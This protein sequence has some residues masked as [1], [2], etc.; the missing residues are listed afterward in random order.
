[1]SETSRAQGYQGLLGPLY[2]PNLVA[3]MA[4]AVGIVIGS[5]GPWAHLFAI[6]KGGT[7]GDGLITLVLGLLATLALF[8]VLNLG[9]LGTGSGWIVWLSGI[10]A[11]M[12]LVCACVAIVDMI[13][14]RSRSAD[15][16]GTKM[17]PE[18]G[19]GL[20]VLLISSIML[21]ATAS[22]VAATAARNQ[23]L[24]RPSGLASQTEPQ[25]QPP[26]RPGARVRVVAA[27][28]DRRGQVGVVHAVL[29]DDGD[30]LTIAVK[31]KDEKEPYA[32]RRD[33]LQVQTS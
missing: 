6:S 32:Y 30:G 13:D 8:S 3:A 11:V 29:E 17:H 25:P 7:D 33:E 23:P 12:G 9:R 27:T 5:L 18:V 28:D 14:V 16:F 22:V 24:T 19:W 2:L 1:M 26:F 31:F 4:A 20:W 10:A 21:S 15:V